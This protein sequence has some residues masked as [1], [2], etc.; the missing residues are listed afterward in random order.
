M[1]VPRKGQPLKGTYVRSSAG[2]P[3]KETYVLDR[4]ASKAFAKQS[5]AQTSARAG[6]EKNETQN[7][8]GSLEPKWHSK[9]HI[10]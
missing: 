4:N 1:S 2:Q 10:K 9:Q 5:M 3:L 8:A 6:K 7:V